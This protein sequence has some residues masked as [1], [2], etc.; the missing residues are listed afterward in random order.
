MDPGDFWSAARMEKSRNTVGRFSTKGS[1]ERELF[2]ASRD[3]R[4]HDLGK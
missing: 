3:P 4:P 1:F 2:D